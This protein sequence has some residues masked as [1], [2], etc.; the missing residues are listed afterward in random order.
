MFS[1]LD[2]AFERSGLPS[3]GT[4]NPTLGSDPWDV[5]I[6]HLL[7][8][9][10]ITVEKLQAPS[11]ADEQLQPL[12]ESV[13][14]VGGGFMHAFMQN[15]AKED[16]SFVDEKN[17]EGV[18]VKLNNAYRWKVS[19]CE[20]I[21]EL[22]AVGSARAQRKRTATDL[23]KKVFHTLNHYE[24]VV[25]GSAMG[26]G[27]NLRTTVAAA[28][29]ITIIIAFKSEDGETKFSADGKPEIGQRRVDM[30]FS[31]KHVV[32]TQVRRVLCSVCLFCCLPPDVWNPTPTAV[33]IL[34][35]GLR[36]PRPAQLR[37][38]GGAV[39][40][41]RGRAQ[42]NAHQHC[43][44]GGNLSLRPDDGCGEARRLGQSLCSSL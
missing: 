9:A 12:H 30:V 39:E 36:A 22:G 33:G 40:A 26:D 28:Q 7:N 32:T 38:V 23:R 34:R 10:G 21:P 24:I 6:H 13:Q 4:T 14:I 29:I 20:D 8:H 2:E 42:A 19:V 17:M 3:Y 5:Y 27:S 18:Q 35:R 37:K 25:D 16:I 15:K 43:R 1:I 11:E 41:H 44:S 31:N